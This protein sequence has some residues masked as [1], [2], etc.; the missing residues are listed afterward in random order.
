MG[1]IAT[2]FASFVTSA[3][4]T[5]SLG[6]AGCG[7]PAQNQTAIPTANETAIVETNPQVAGGWTSFT[8]TTPA[9]TKDE[10][11]VFDQA[12]KG[13]VGVNYELVRVLGTQVVA[14]TNYAFLA[15][16]TTVTAKPTC[17]WY[18]LVAYQDLKGNVTLTS[19]KPIDLAKPATTDKVADG[20][21]VGGWQVKNPSNAI[22]E[23][24]EAGRA[25]FK[26]AENY[27]GI[28]LSPIAT[29]G[30]QVVSGTNYLVLCQ[31]TPVTENPTNQL[32]LATLYV[33]LQGNAKLTNVS[34]FDLTA[35]MGQGE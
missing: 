10:R 28:N 31:G 12:T 18:I 32:Y 22:L 8:D 14:G 6:F 33:D 21:L 3:A 24:Q 11:G 16:G 19:I 1:F 2:A 27:E 7:G 20:N 34:G 29:L 25:F 17:G 15:R 9:A 23:P 4:L 26:A 30:T 13:L 35:Y 5:A